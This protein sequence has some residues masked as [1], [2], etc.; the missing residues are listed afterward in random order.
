MCDISFLKCA[1]STSYN[2]VTVDSDSDSDSELVARRLKI[3]AK[4]TIMHCTT[5][6]YDTRR[7]MK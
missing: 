3:K 7:E 1:R 6:Q 4:Q 5:K 2:Y